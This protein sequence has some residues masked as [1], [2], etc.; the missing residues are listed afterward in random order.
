[1]TEQVDIVA[2]K[3]PCALAVFG[4]AARRARAPARRQSDVNT[5]QDKAPERKIGVSEGVIEA[6]R[7]AG[8]KFQARGGQAS[9]HE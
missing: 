8:P 7:D 3:W 1:M 2:E 6:V 5:I 9:L 4:E